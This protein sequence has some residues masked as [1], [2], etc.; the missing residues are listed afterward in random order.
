MTM[1]PDNIQ[2]ALVKAAYRAG[3]QGLH[4]RLMRRFWGFKTGIG[5]E[6]KVIDAEVDRIR[7]TE[8]FPFDV[9]GPDAVVGVGHGG[10]D[11]LAKPIA[12][13]RLFR[14]LEMRF[15]EGLPWERTP[16]YRR[17]VI[18]L[19]R[20]GRTWNSC[21][22][23]A[24]VDERCLELDA[25]YED[26]KR[27]GYR[28]RQRGR[29]HCS[30]RGVAVPDEIRVAVA[31]D[32]QFIRCENGRHRLAMAGFLGIET[33]PAI[34]QLEHRGW[35]GHMQVKKSIPIGKRGGRG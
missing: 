2:V 11:Q 26:M 15:V 13:T 8:K 34:V 1:M 20:K 9:E 19:R 29:R 35:G 25:M 33:V 31:R 28:F 12:Q 4:S 14:S 22:S 30:V 24:E 7:L 23:L 18:E 32:G 17:A 27:N 3:M 10:W 5:Y 16:K 21:S 6:L